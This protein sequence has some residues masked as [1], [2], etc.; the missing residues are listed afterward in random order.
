MNFFQIADNGEP[1]QF[2]LVV[3]MAEDESNEESISTGWVVLRRLPEFQELHR[4]LRQLCSNVKN[5]ELPS[6]PLKFFG[7]SD[8]NSLD[9]A[10]I[11]IQKYLNVRYVPFSRRK[12]PIMKKNLLSLH[13]LYTL[14]YVLEDDRLNQ[15]EALYAFL[16][17]SS[18]HLKHTA[19]SPKKSRFSLSTLFKR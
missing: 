5:L 18:E 10:K 8:K 7:K 15:S 13:P 4:K 12:L 14:Q 3:H 1:P 11:Q 19:P 17:P 6:Q 16:S 9:K 2:V